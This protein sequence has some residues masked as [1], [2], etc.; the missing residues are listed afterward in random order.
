M[1]REFLAFFYTSTLN[2]GLNEQ[3]L[4][5]SDQVFSVGDEATIG[6]NKLA[7]VGIEQ[8]TGLYSIFEGQ[9]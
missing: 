1:V 5:K 7:F 2:G 9:N 6:L 3:A 8:V 4:A